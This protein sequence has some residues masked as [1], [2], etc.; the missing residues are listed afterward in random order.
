MDSQPDISSW[1]S[2]IVKHLGKACSKSVSS[3]MLDVLCVDAGIKPSYLFDVACVDARS[4]HGFVRQLHEG[5]MIK[6]QLSVV[7]VEEDVFVVHPDILNIVS[8]LNTDVTIVNVSDS[9]SQPVTLA[10]EATEDILSGVI[11]QLRGCIV[12]TSTSQVITMSFPSSVNI[13]T[14]FGYLLGYP[15]LYWQ[16]LT[17]VQ[18]CLGMVP[19]I[20]VKVQFQNVLKESSFVYDS[21]S[22]SVPKHIFV[23]QKLDGYIDG[24][25]AKIRMKCEG[26]FTKPVLLKPEVVLPAVAM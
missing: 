16:N 11:T 12:D 6:R 5:N 14:V 19:L 1:K 15:I 9:L 24:W 13:P 21:F 2:L 4:L 20:T 23:T 3:I 26:I 8:Q 10:K 18:N 22:F 17:S 7:V 25:F